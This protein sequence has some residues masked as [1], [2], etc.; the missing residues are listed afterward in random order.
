MN[1]KTNL[2]MFLV[3][4]VSGSSLIHEYMSEKDFLE[5]KKDEARGIVRIVEHTDLG[6]GAKA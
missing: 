5:L 6:I 1:S 3:D 4:Y 2:S